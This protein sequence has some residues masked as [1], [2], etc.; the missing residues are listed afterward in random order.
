M[1]NQKKTK[2]PECKYIK[3]NRYYCFYMI[4]IGGTVAKWLAPTTYTSSEQDLSPGFESCVLC[5][6]CVLSL[7]VLSVLGGFPLG[8]PL[9]S[10]SRKTCF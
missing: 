1:F 2:N 6:M 3:L 9:S 7:N 5:P 10:H 4:S 8:T